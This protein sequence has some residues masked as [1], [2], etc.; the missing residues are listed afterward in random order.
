MNLWS[1]ATVLSS[2]LTI[3]TCWVLLRYFATV[4]PSQRNLIT[5]Y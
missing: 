3:L 4:L 2:L 5:R 1:L